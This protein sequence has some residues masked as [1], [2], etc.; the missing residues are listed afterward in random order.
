[1]MNDIDNIL[2]PLP[3][4]EAAAPA[5][6]AAPTGRKTPPHRIAMAGLSLA[7][8]LFAAFVVWPTLADVAATRQLIAG[9]AAYQQGDATQLGDGDRVLPATERGLLATKLKTLTANVVALYTDSTDFAVQAQDVQ[10]ATSLRDRVLALR[11]LED[12]LRLLYQRTTEEDK[13]MLD[14][15]FPAIVDQASIVKALEKY[16]FQY[17]REHPFDQIVISNIQFGGLLDNKDDY[18]ATYDRMAI[19]LA[20][21]ST[22]KGILDLLDVLRDTGMLSSS[23][24]AIYH[25]DLPEESTSTAMRSSLQNIRELNMGMPVMD[26]ADMSLAFPK[27]RSV[28]D[29]ASGT[30]TGTA[31]TTYKMTLTTHLL[32]RRISSEDLA[33]LRND[34]A[35]VKMDVLEVPAQYRDYVVNGGLPIASFPTGEQTIITNYRT[36]YTSFA[37]TLQERLIESDLSAADP[38]SNAYANLRAAAE[39]SATQF[40]A[41]LDAAQARADDA[42]S[43]EDNRTAYLQYRTILRSLQGLL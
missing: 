32:V 38:T 29:L 36:Q 42:E 19:T 30:T 5:D 40:V 22:Q 39:R 10:D 9:L 13:K 15:I 12:Q 33:E 6:V 37:S 1:M 2:P 17:N 7:L 18:E 8:V 20:I 26:V 21:E 28:F 41:L 14:V 4:D 23:A 43:K 16:T 25:P 24:L 35:Q 27:P 34:I 11:E 31:D 3:G